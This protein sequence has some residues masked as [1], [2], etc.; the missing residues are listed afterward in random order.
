MTSAFGLITQGE[1]PP[2]I[3]LINFATEKDGKG[4]P[5]SKEFGPLHMNCGLLA[6]LGDDA[7][8]REEAN[9]LALGLCVLVEWRE[10]L[11]KDDYPGC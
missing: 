7:V 2:P 6:F 8:G 9:R 5:R 11:S 3:S 1:P 10:F 4:R